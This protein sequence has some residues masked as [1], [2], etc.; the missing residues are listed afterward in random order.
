MRRSKVSFDTNDQDWRF[1]KKSLKQCIAMRFIT[2]SEK[3]D[4]L[5]FL[6]T[7]AEA[8]LTVRGLMTGSQSVTSFI[9]SLLQ[10]AH[11]QRDS[12]K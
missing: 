3:K 5:N 12:K 6:E 4:I 10:A 9:L 2:E 11:A 8:E 1:V 7:T